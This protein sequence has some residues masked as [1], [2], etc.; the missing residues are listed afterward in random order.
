MLTTIVLAAAAAANP[1]SAPEPVSENT[2][3]WGTEQFRFELGGIY[4]LYTSAVERGTDGESNKQLVVDSSFG[5]YGAATYRVWGPI[6]LGLFGQFESGNRRAGEF[7]GEFDENDSSKAL[8]GPR[9]GGNYWE[10]WFGPLIRAQYKG[11][12]AEFGWGA[13]GIRNDEGRPDLPEVDGGTGTFRTDPGLAWLIGIGGALEIAD[14]IQLILRINYRIRYYT[15][16]GGDDFQ[17]GVAHGT[18]D[19]IP[20]VGLAWVIDR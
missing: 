6:S 13:V 20:F 14:P 7:T 8:V 10:F 3:L 1:T 17:D 12:F 18:Q 16:R 11:V 5:L 9:T 4:S 15:T 19:I 2:R